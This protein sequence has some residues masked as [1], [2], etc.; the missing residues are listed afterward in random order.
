MLSFKLMMFCCALLDITKALTV[1]VDES[2]V[3]AFLKQRK[4]VNEVTFPKFHIRAFTKNCDQIVKKLVKSIYEE[5]LEYLEEGAGVDNK[6]YR[7]CLKSEFVRHKMDEKFLKASAFDDEPQKTQLEQIRDAFLLNIKFS[8]SKILSDESSNRFKD[9]V[10][11]KGGPSQKLSKHPAIVKISENV[12]CMNLYAV[13][14]K[15]L[16]PTAY[17]LKLRPINQTDDDCKRVVSDVTTLIMDEWHIRRYSED[18][19]IQRCFNDVLLQTQAVEFFIKNTLLSRMQ[20]TQEQKDFERE[21]FV[22]NAATI[23]DKTYKCIS[24]GFEKI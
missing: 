12:I 18:D 4:I 16:D 20:L 14:N 1:S 15:I 5:N 3:V 2:C 7:D 22:K 13:E 9:F 19:K 10:S 6:T 24:N 17:K 23:H 8:C 11:D 21:K